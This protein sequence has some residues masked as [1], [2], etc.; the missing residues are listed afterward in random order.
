MKNVL[1]ILLFCFFSCKEHKERTPQSQQPKTIVKDTITC[2]DMKKSVWDTLV[3]LYEKPYTLGIKKYAIE[4]TKIIK[5]TEK[6]VEVCY[7]LEFELSLIE[8]NQTVFRVKINDSLFKNDFNIENASQ[9]RL[10]KITLDGFRTK[11]IYYSCVFL[12]KDKDKQEYESKIRVNYLGKDKG[13][14][15]LFTKLELKE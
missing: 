4:E 5:E 15:F 7:D 6:L 14:P 3:K 10:A 12:A 9:Y 1:L 2:M 11:S 8:E 13:K